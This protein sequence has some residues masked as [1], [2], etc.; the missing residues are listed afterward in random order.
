MADGSRRRSWVGVSLIG[1]AGV[2]VLTGVAY[3]VF[4]TQADA[5]AGNAATS[6]EVTGSVSQL[7]ARQLGKSGLPLPR[8]VSLKT[9]RVNVRRGP[10]SEHGVSWVFNRRELPVEI[11]AEFDHWRRVRDADGE[12]GWIYQSLLAGRRTAMVAPWRKDNNVTM[13]NAPAK[14]AATVALVRGG[15]IGRINTCDGDWCSL[16]VAGYEGWIEQAMLW[17]V[18]PGEYIR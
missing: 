6:P 15:V 14:D 11:V 10:S 7:P 1:L 2:L 18:Y 8:F 5:T 13:M 4:G 12:E 3:A 16:S 17:G 9:D